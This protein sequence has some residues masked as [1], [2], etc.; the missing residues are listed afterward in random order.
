MN[1][2]CIQ[3]DV[4]LTVTTVKLHDYTGIKIDF[5]D[6]SKLNFS[7]IGYNNNIL[8]EITYEVKEK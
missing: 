6:K 1:L 7:M 4:P 3:E 2:F 8:E 5:T